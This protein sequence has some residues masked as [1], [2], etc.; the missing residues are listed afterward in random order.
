MKGGRVTRHRWFLL[1]AAQLLASVTAAG[2]LLVGGAVL[3]G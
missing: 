3:Q 1:L 2:V